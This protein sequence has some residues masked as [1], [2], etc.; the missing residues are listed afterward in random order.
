[1][2]K[3]PAPAAEEP[4]APSGAAARAVTALAAGIALLVA[5]ALPLMHWSAAKARLAGAVETSARLHAAE[6]AELARSNPEFWQFEGLRIAAP[7]QA[8]ARVDAERRR[9]FA[10]DGRLVIES[11][12]GG[13]LRRP[14]LAWREPVRG[15]DGQ[16]IGETEAARSLHG[17]VVETGLIALGSA[18]IGAL[19]MLGLRLIPLR[20]LAQALERAAYLAAHDPLT[21]LP[22]RT[23]FADRL[24]Q[25]LALAQRDGS[26]VAVFCLD[27]DRFKEVNDTLG[28]AAGDKLLREM[29]AR[30]GACL[31]ASDTLARLGGDE[32]AVIQTR[33]RQPGDAE[34]LAR[35]LLAA[36]AAPVMIE[37]RPARVGLS[38]GIAVAA[39]GQAVPPAALLKDADTA[40]Y[41][42]KEQGRGTWRF[43]S[44]EMNR[45]L[46]E[47]RALEADL[48]VALA[49]GGLRLHYQPQIDLA[50]GRI[51]GAEALLRWDRPGHGPVPP[52]DFIPIA[53]ESGLIAAIG[54]W[55]LRE[56]CAE[57]AGWA[58]ELSVAV[59]VSPAQ[60]RLPGLVTAVERALAHS[61]LA[62][63]RLEIEITESVLLSDAEDTLEILD[64]LR[65]LGVR[66]AM[67]DF[68]TGYS[69]LGY[70]RKFPFDKVKI[71]RSFVH[72]LGVDPNADAI[73]RAVVSVSQALGMRTT[74]EGV[75]NASQAAALKLGGCKEAQGY[76]ISRPLPPGE[77]A[78]LLAKNLA[79]RAA[80]A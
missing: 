5:V 79:E 42:A 16:P 47:R 4:R 11:I 39:M 62:P 13:G 28:H 36:V 45:R 10:A 37:D 67:D 8:V 27:L 12:T 54:A 77:F 49:S 61:G 56:A 51:T 34:A 31:R 21:G 9:V 76:L 17:V 25:A 80:A 29:A 1:L 69:T 41:Q 20:L 48:T 32:F 15:P 24:G 3:T 72:D 55:A 60:F 63:Q 66:I 71:D 18:L 59:N 50:S 26:A 68:G 44:P 22:N 70:L 7:G 43:F 53:E 38:V 30:F 33:A 52:M 78:A 58:E 23:V 74:A 40:L 65:A 57:A 73:V 14:V 75:E 6:V 35:R 2:R 19:A 46:L 64:R